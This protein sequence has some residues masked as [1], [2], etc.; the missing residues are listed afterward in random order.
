MFILPFL[1]NSIQGYFRGMGQMTMTLVCTIIQISVRT[2]MVYLLVPGIGIRG[3]AWGSA[4]GW[5]I[6]AI[7]EYGYYFTIQQRKVYRKV[8]N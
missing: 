2:V 5:I 6:M 3:E 1:T 8:E 7:F 4:L